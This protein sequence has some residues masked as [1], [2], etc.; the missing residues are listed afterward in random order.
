MMIPE[1]Q[2]SEKEALRRENDDLHQ[3]RR[4]NEHAMK[5][6]DRRINE[7]EAICKTEFDDLNDAQYSE[8]NDI[9][10]RER[11]KELEDGGKLDTITIL[12]YEDKV[13]ELE[14]VAHEYVSQSYMPEPKHDAIRFIRLCESV[15][16]DCGHTVDET[17]MEVVG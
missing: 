17:E 6:K 8:W 9:A 15:G 5:I 14:D 2:V 11:I 7:L 12:D 13:K 3:R 4:E 1:M 16:Y 10:G